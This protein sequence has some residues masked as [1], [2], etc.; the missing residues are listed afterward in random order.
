MD[1]GFQAAAIETA[2]SRVAIDFS[3]VVFILK[4][5]KKVIAIPSNR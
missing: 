4:K 3:I 1:T 2:T 5:F